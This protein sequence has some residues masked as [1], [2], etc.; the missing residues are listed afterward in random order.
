MPTCPLCMRSLETSVHLMIECPLAQQIWHTLVAWQNCEGVT[1]ALQSKPCSISAF[2]ESWMEATPAEH[3]K[4]VGSLLILTCWNI[5][6]ERNARIFR[7]KQ[8]S[9]LQISRCI[10][11]E[12][13]E[14]AFAG[15]KALRKLLWEPP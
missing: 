6:R 8:C 13:Q 14:W 1:T 11:D 9:V 5:W 4:G 10:K 2:R 3:K 7:D 12:A 15:A